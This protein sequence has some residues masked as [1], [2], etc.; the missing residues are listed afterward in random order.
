MKCTYLC[1]TVKEIFTSI[2]T[3]W[4]W[5]AEKIYA[6]EGLVIPVSTVLLDKNLKRTVQQSYIS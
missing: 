1:N 5:K 4:H 2:L 6:F 3:C